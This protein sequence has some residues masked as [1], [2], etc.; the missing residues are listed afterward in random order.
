MKQ[1]NITN[2][3]FPKGFTLRPS[4]PRSV[5]VRGIGAAPHLY[6]A[7][8]P[9]GMT[10]YVARGFTLIELLVVV[11]I[12][13]ILAAVA[14]PQ[15]N[16]A[17]EKARV[18]EARVMLNAIYKGY[19]LCILQYGTASDKC[20][21]DEN[22]A[23]NVNNN[24]LA[25]MDIELPGEIVNGS[26]ETCADTDGYVCVITKDWV[27]GADASDSWWANRIQNG[28]SPYFLDLDLETGA[29]TCRNEDVAGSCAH[30]CGSNRC[31]VK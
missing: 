13:G 16:K 17:V 14:L 12:I 11:L 24:L 4:S 25:N 29:I 26:N 7:Q 3:L 9:C 21:L 30:I 6:P 15:Y 18:A 28:T 2:K 8:K 31:E 22:D 23:S 27:Y 5:A 10:K 20:T 19:Q 1:Q